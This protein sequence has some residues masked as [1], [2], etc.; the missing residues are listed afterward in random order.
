[1]SVSAQ[2]VPIFVGVS[3]VKW[4]WLYLPRIAADY[5]SVGV[6]NES[7]END[8]PDIST[9]GEN[10]LPSTSSEPTCYLLESKASTAGWA[11]IR[12]SIEKAIVERAVLPQLQTCLNCPDPASIWCKRCGPKS[13]FCEECFFNLHRKV[14]IFH[15]AEIWK[16]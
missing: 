1:M 7:V 5:D 13:Y 6:P 15:V 11:T 4:V 8:F 9:T 16:V 10:I 3:H 2:K 12:G 14:N